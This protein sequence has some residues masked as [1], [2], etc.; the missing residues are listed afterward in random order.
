MPEDRKRSTLDPRSLAPRTGTAYPPLFAGEV[1]GREK[2]ALGD[3]FGLTQFGVNL[4]VL[5]PG[6][7]SSHRHWHENEDELVYIVDGEVVLIDDE[8]EHPMSAGM[9]VG[10][11]AGAPNGHHLINRSDRP[12]TYLEI[13]TRA[14]EDRV[15]YCEVDMDLKKE[16]GGPWKVR[17]KDGTSY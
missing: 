6:R 2:R 4:T 5:P 7:W 9:C 10:W 17:H 14:S 8:G 3:V 11:K 12:A 1:E 15:H 16:A 13:G